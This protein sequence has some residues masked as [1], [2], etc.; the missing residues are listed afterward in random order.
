MSEVVRRGGRIEWLDSA[1]GIAIILVVLGHCIGYIDDPLNKVILSFHMPAF[2]FLSGICM[3]REESWKAFA[4]K[5][6]QRIVG[7]QILLAG[8]CMGYD[9]I[10][11]H[12]INFVSN[13]FV[14]FLPVL[15]CSE[16]VFQILCKV[17]S[18]NLK[19]CVLLVLI[20]GLLQLLPVHTV[21]H[22][23]IVPTAVLFLALG[24]S[25]KNLLTENHNLIEQIGKYGVVALPFVVLLAEI[26]QPVM[27]YNNDYGNYAL[28]I[29]AAIMGCLVIIAMGKATQ[30]SDVLQSF[31]RNS[32]L[33]Y[34][35]H[36]RMTGVLHF[37]ISK[38]GSTSY[39]LYLSPFY[40]GI[41]GLEMLTLYIAAV[42]YE[43]LRRFSR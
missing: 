43:R 6:F 41:F 1:R 26:N 14:W 39:D 38:V 16:I 24:Y 18:V 10:Q 31:G 9:F 37:L 5:R 12:S 23:E 32:I 25:F 27:M 35:L 28:F 19:T 11:S 13:L 29:L 33:I 20:S 17:V 21:I 40:W 4:K 7:W 36:F 34:V 8:I 2:F 15:F 22:I 30:R 3:K 42:L